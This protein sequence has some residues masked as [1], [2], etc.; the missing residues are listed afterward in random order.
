M[1]NPHWQGTCWYGPVRACRNYQER[2]SILAPAERIDEKKFT[3]AFAFLF[4]FAFAFLFVFA[5]AFVFASAF[6]LEFES[7]VSSSGRQ[8]PQT[9][10]EGSGVG[11]KWPPSSIL[12]FLVRVRVQGRDPKRGP[13][14]DTSWDPTRDS[15]SSRVFDFEC[16]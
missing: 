12:A 8:T 15:E 1:S 4:V 11:C 13:R 2:R 16:C 5:F 3:F 14:D 6:D 9:D 10:H 7:L